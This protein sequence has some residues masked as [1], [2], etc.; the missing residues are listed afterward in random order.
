MGRMNEYVPEKE[1]YHLFID[2][3]GTPSVKDS[4]SEVYILSG[5]CVHRRE[6]APIKIWADRIK[7]KY[8]GR[9]DVV[10]HSREIGRKEN[11]FSIFADEEVFLS[12]LNDLKAFLIHSRF[13]MFF[14]VTD[15]NRAREAGWN[16]IKVCRDASLHLV[17]NFFLAL[18]ALDSK[19]E[20]VVE[21]ASPSKDIYMMDALNYFLAEGLPK[22]DVSHAIAQNT[23]TSISFVTKRNH[24]IEEQIADLFAYAAKLKFLLLTENRRVDDAYGR[25]MLEL[26]EKKSFI[27]PRG[28]K[29]K[30]ALFYSEIEPFLVLP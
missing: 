18:L 3:L 13:R 7:F 1:Y 17:R 26:L 9:T 28:A 11:D 16:D 4:T 10:F 15:K 29:N 8:W 22:H 25:M 21:A 6:C 23:L 27:V 20:I 12:F 19:G 2:E 30:K 24:D 14:I 5:C